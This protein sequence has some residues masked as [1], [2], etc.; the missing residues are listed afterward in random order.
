MSLTRLGILRGGPSDEYELSME[1]GGV[2]RQLAPAHL[3][4]VVDIFVDRKGVWHIGGIPIQP[5]E[6]RDKVDIIFNALHG[7]Y[8][9]DGTVQT[10]LQNLSM[11]FTGSTALASSLTH[12]KHHLKKQLENLGIK[13]PRYEIF[14]ISSTPEIDDISLALFHSFSMPMIIKPVSSG[15]SYGVTLVRSFDELLTALHTAYQYSS[16]I[17]AEEYIAGA[18]VVSGFVDKFRNEKVYP[19]MP[20]EIGKN[21]TEFFTPARLDQS[22]KDLIVETVKSLRQHLGLRHAATFDFIVSPRRG[23]FLLEIDTN[24]PLTRH[25]PLPRALEA[26]GIKIS[27]YIHHL[28]TLARFQK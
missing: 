6:I 22:S 21:R 8:G 1:N 20:V 13:T 10:I 14:N 27:D 25:S 3:Y 9:E 26:A 15:S 4:Q 7:S 16:T 2:I 28:L 24:P 5:S 23:V 17:M 12:H 19:I 11:P 18:E